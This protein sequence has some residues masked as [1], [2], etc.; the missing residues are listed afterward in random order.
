MFPVTTEKKQ[1]PFSGEKPRAVIHTGANARVR[2]PG[3][4]SDAA[5]LG[6]S[7][8]HLYLVLT[9]ERRSRS[10]LTRYK[11]LKRAAKVA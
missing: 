2:F 5:A 3:I 11:A 4:V 8:I 9:G 10:L 6:V 7:R 1:R